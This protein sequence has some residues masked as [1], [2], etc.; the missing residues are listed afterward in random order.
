MT[1]T[2]HISY[3]SHLSFLLSSVQLFRITI[4]IVQL[5]YNVHARIHIN[6]KPAY[7]W[8]LC[9]ERLSCNSSKIMCTNICRLFSSSFYGFFFPSLYS[10]VC[11]LECTRIKIC[12]KIS[13]M[14]IDN[15]SDGKHQFVKIAQKEFRAETFSSVAEGIWEDGSGYSERM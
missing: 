13:H 9:G 12:W 11:S 15:F 3:Y 14:Q 6:T 4:A 1:F 8:K 2:V 10:F 5:Q 7:I